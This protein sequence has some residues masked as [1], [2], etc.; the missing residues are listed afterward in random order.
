MKGRYVEFNESFRRIC[1]YTDEELKA[2]DYWAL[3][4]KKYEAE[5]ARQL[6]S[7]ARIGHYGPYEKEYVR[8]DGSLVPLRLSGVLVTDRDGEKY[9]W[10]IVEDIT[11]RKQTEEVLRRTQ[12]EL[13][14]RVK[15]RTAELEKIN[16]E[17]ASE[18]AERRRAER[19]LQEL[20]ETLEKRVTQRSAE[21]KRRAEEME[22]FVHVASHDLKA[23]L[24]GVANLTAWL[25]ED[26]AGKLSKDTGET[27][28]LLQDRVGR[29][30]ALLEGLLEFS[31]IGRTNETKEMADTKVLLDETIDL[32]SLPTGVVVD[33]APGMPTLHTNKLLLGRVF[34]NLVGNAIK[35]HG[36]SQAHVWVTAR[37]AGEFYEF[38]VADDGPGIAPQYH[39]KV[40]MMFQTLATRDVGT[41]SGIGLALVKK[42]VEEYGGSI[43]LDSEVDKGSTF[44]FKWPK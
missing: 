5:E 10:S 12:G 4:P 35:H 17:L 2:L 14:T 1:G 20:N 32:L 36:G 18:V 28:E 42:I 23:P 34:A 38:S 33:V 7:L 3:T 19:E 27:F 15:E 44:R 8:C 9:I 22:Q 6:E 31:R 40:F 43:T 30:H 11:E 24:R 16:R 26:L 41:D 25:Q 37:D 13:E 21:A 29:M 39:Q